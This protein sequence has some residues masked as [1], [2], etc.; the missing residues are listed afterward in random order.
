[1]VKTEKAEIYRRVKLLSYRLNI[2]LYIYK[3][4]KKG[5]K[6][7]WKNI[8]FKLK[9]EILERMFIKR[10]LLNVLPWSLELLIYK[11]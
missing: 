2:N 1:M 5:S 11:Y 6:T 8:L 3:R 10:N 4:Y 9:V 7:Y